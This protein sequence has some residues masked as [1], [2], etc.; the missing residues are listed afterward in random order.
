VSVD[1]CGVGED[2]HEEVRKHHVVIAD[3]ASMQDE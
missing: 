2:Q 3:A 1:D